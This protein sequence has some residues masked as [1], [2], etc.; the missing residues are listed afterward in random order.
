MDKVSR[1][2]RRS[3]DVGEQNDDVTIGVDLG[4]RKSHVCML[5]GR[6]EIVR[7]EAITT[8]PASFREHFQKIPRAVVALEVGTH[9]RWASRVLQDCGHESDRGQPMQSEVHL[10]ERRQK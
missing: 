2:R 10:L 5:D 1:M 8:S 7:E 3:S 6:G 4:D 9:S